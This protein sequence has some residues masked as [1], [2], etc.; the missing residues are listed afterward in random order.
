M[1]EVKFCE[2]CLSKY[3]GEVCASCGGKGLP[4]PAAKP[5]KDAGKK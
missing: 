4:K 5:K 1:T 3:V 2:K